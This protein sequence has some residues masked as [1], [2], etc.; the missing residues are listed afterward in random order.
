MHTHTLATTA[1]PT[2]PA[3]PR[4]R[5]LAVRAAADSPQ[6]PK[7]SV[8]FSVEQKV[9]FGQRV[10]VLGSKESLGA[11]SDP[12]ALTWG[13]GDV[14]TGSA[15]VEEDGCV[16]LFICSF[17]PRESGSGRGSFSMA[18]TSALTPLS[19][20]FSHPFPSHSS[21]ALEYKLLTIGDDGAPITWQTGPNRALDLSGAAAGTLTVKDTLEGEGGPVVEAAAAVK[22]AAPAPAPAPASVATIAAAAPA[23]APTPTPMPTPTPSIRPPPFAA[24]VAAAAASPAASVPLTSLTVNELKAKLKASGKPVTGTKAV[25]IERL[26]KVQRG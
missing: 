16:D 13:E 12:L 6:P 22:K 7:V 2:R 26:Q 17:F 15:E 24:V 11:W 19:L 8:R 21:S 4:A 14:W 18:R 5:V 3:A 1:L 20:S 10:A 23:K 25:L 9:P